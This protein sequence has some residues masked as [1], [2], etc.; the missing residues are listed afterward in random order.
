MWHKALELFREIEASGGK[1]SI[2]TYNATM[3]ALEKGLQWERA[4]DL[5]DEMKLKNM[6]VTVVSYGS[7]ISA[8]EK[9]KKTAA[10][11]WGPPC[12]FVS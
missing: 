2:V 10:S 5:F 3:T 9:G 7:A 11:H 12:V 1:P 8:C 6:P 4:L